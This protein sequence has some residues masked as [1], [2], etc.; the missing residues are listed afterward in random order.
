MSEINLIS[1]ILLNAS[2]VKLQYDILGLL[3]GISVDTSPKCS[4]IAAKMPLPF[5]LITV[6]VGYY[7]GHIIRLQS[8]QSLL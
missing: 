1:L 8:F 2:F 3:L 4:D 6:Q 5:N 7:I